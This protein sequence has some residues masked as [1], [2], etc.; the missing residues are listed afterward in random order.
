MR[1]IKILFVGLLSLLSCQ[2]DQKKKLNLYQFIPQNTQA[3]IQINE[4]VL[5]KETWNKNPSIKSLSPSNKETEVLISLIKETSEAISI[6]CFSPIGKDKFSSILIQKKDNDT[7]MLDSKD[8]NYSNYSNYSGVIIKETSIE[9]INL[10]KIQIAQSEITSVS[11]LIIENIIRNYQTNQPG[12][13]DKDFYQLINNLE[14]K[15]VFNILINKKSN[16]FINKFLPQPYLFPNFNESW[17]AFD[18]NFNSP[19]IG[20]DGITI[21]KDSIPSRL[22]VFKNLNLDKIKSTKIIPQSFNS[23][24]SFP[25]ENI[26]QLADQIKKYSNY[27][28]IALNSMSLKD[29]SSIDEITIMEHSEGNAVILHRS[30]LNQSI[31][32]PTTFEKSFRNVQYG[33]IDKNP[34]ALNTVLDLFKIKF[35]AKF[36]ASIND[37]YILS[38]Q[39]SLI[40]TIIS[41]VK[42]AT[43]ID[44]S[45]N[46]ISLTKNLSDLNSGIWVSKTNSFN[47]N[48][49]SVGFDS[50]KYPLTAMQWVNDNEISHLHIRFGVEVPKNKNTVINQGSINSEFNISS[51]PKWLKNH[52]SKGYD[53]VFQDK[54][55]TLYLYSNTGNLFWKK[56]LPEKIIGDISQVDLYKNKK[57]Q[58]AFRTKNHFMILDRNGKIVIPFDKIIK[59]KS[60]ALPLSVFDYDGNRNYRF[61]LAQ[62]KN[63]LML[64]SK[65]EKV[66]GFKFSKTNSSIINPAK[67]IRIKGKDFIILQEQSGKLNI[68]NRRGE[69]IVN[70]D[71]YLSFSKNPIWSYLNTFTTSDVE[72]NMV[73]IDTKGNII[74]TPEG[75]AP[76]HLLEMTTKTLVSISENILT[77]KGIPVKLP[78][79]NYTRPKIFYINNNIY[80]ST[81]EKD[82][83]KVYLFLSNGTSVEGFPVF[84]IE[85]ADIVN[86]DNDD[87]LEMIVQSESDGIIIYQIN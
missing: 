9:G 38:S 57:F 59:S 79:G 84:G 32:N 69:K 25:I 56:Q 53:I 31:I 58:M 41:S 36:S 78:Y 26:P 48:K 43:T 82:S 66:N 18:G 29:F 40:K 65:G 33:K 30:N 39:E 47:E 87:S 24:I 17:I 3:V 60:K 86:A 62:D 54:N 49:S 10:F 72:G 45:E 13:F 44:N 27:Y 14:S 81:T 77:I 21:T 15:S 42:D 73:Q 8:S 2:T 1:Y 28:N 37:Y 76:N 16:S 74:K 80:I 34:K 52:R 4:S 19:L 7:L 35:N 20:L 23:F 46:F 64:D 12:I 11:K 85:T 50:K 61:L 71:S 63:L 6:L 55:N 70:I 51:N 75:W 68:L 67:H 83:Q 5:F 22:G